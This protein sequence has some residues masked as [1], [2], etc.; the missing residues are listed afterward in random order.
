MVLNK[1]YLAISEYYAERVAERSGVLLI[2]HIREGLW[3]LDHIGAS[4]AVKDAFCLHP[5]VQSDEALLDSLQPGSALRQFDPDPIAVV[6]AMEYRH[7][8]NAYLSHHCMGETDVIELSRL[9]EVNQMLIAD[10]V[11]NRKDF[12]RYHA[13]T[14]ARSAILKTYFGNWLKRLN[15]SEKQYQYFVE[16]LAATVGPSGA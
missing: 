15:V 4:Q 1:H 12:E 6:L 14:H 16:A 7:T 5:L 2:E 8:A 13:A 3:L 10:K 11:Q 9:E